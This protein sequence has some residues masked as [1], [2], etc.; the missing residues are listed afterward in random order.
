MREKSPFKFTREQSEEVDALLRRRN[1]PRKIAERA[2]IVRLLMDGHSGYAAAEGWFS[3][4]ERF[5]LRG[6]AFIVEFNRHSA[7]PFQWTKDADSILASVARAKTALE[8][9]EERVVMK[10]D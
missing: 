5:G 3:R 8:T 10:K 9:Q 4:V 2:R 1:A 6:R 7:K